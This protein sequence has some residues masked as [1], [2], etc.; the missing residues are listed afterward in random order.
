TTS[1]VCDSD[2][3][4]HG[5]SDHGRVSPKPHFCCVVTTELLRL[6]S[7]PFL[8]QQSLIRGPHWAVLLTESSVNEFRTA[9]H[10]RLKETREDRVPWKMWGPYLAEREWGT[11]RE[12]YSPNGD[13]WHY[14]THDEARSRAYR[15]GEDGIAGIS[16]DKQ[17][18]CFAL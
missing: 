12:D 9:E 8:V 2:W 11:V 10:L 7:S 3:R 17:R 14:F 18:L 6:R 4:H 15:W 1:A 13:A 5:H 16:D